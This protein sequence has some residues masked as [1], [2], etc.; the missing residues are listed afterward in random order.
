MRTL[1]AAM[2][3]V[4]APL[5]ASA[6]EDEEALSCVKTQ[7][8]ESYKEGW[9]LRTMRGAKLSLDDRRTSMVSL[10]PGRAYRFLAC[11]TESIGDLDLVLYDLDGKVVA[12]DTTVDRRPQLDVTDKVGTYY[13][14]VHV[15]SLVKP[16][17]GGVAVA[18][19]HR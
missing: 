18:V 5:T 13:L 4:L 17:L 9:A 10:Y 6:Q 19:T 3:L 1:I 2:A 16:G 7:V 14:V 15:R 11:G 8:W 12:R